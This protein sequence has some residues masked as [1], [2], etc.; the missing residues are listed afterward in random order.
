MAKDENTKKTKRPKYKNK[1]CVIDG[2]KFDSIAEGDY[3]LALKK[4]KEKGLI[5]GFKLQPK[6][7]IQEKFKHATEGNIRAIVYKADFLIHQLGEEK[8]SL[9]VDVKG[10]ATSDAN[11]KRKMF[12]KKY[13]E[14]ELIW[15]SKSLKHGV[16]GWICYFKLEKIR[17][18]NR[19]KKALLKNKQPVRR[20]YE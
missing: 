13:P 3:Y 20:E 8:A 5:V 12:L 17:R 2:I 7:T 1:K 16:N 18:E 9:V 6:F 14:Y 19:K 15:E 10:Q 4:S 11:N